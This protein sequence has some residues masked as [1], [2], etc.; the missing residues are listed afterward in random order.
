MKRVTTS[1]TDGMPGLKK[2]NQ[3]LLGYN[4]RRLAHTADGFSNLSDRLNEL[5]L[6]RLLA[7]YD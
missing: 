3:N 1:W 5:Y 7:A 4:K 2:L 6:V